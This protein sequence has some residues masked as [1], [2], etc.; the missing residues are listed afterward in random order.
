[1][2]AFLLWLFNAIV[3]NKVLM[4]A[5]AAAGG[6][7]SLFVAGR[8]SQAKKDK[9]AQD[10]AKLRAAQDRLQMNREG[11]EAKTTAAGMTDAD[12]RKEAE[13]WARK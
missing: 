9:A 12:A 8:R 11:D 6:A 5:I 10:G 3:G 7:I 13:K 4:G 1:M 2:G